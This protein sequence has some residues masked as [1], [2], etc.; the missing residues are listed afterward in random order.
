MLFP[1]RS[2]LSPRLGSTLTATRRNGCRFTFF[3]VSGTRQVVDYACRPSVVEP[4]N[5][6]VSP[7]LPLT[8][9]KGF[10][11]KVNAFQLKFKRCFNSSSQA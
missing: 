2:F 3:V 9:C 11:V 10:P 1:L 5:F 6:F 8:S 7:S 4:E